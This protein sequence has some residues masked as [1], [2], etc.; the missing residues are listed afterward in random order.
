MSM[1]VALLSFAFLVAAVCAAIMGYAIQRGATC[2]VAAVDEVVTK[3]TA[4]RFLGLTEAAV[5][6]AGGVLLWR[7]LGGHETLPIGYPATLATVAGGLL[8]GLGA[9]VTRA[10]VFG[11]IAKF[12]S[13]EWAY[14]LTPIGFYLGCLTIW[15]LIGSFPAMHVASPLFDA[16][17]LLLPFAA[18][19]SWRLVEA[20]R[21]GR[22]RMLAAHIWTPHR[23]TAVIGIVFAI[24]LIAIGPWA[25]TYALLSLAQ[26]KTDGVIVKAVLMVMLFAGALVGGWTAGRLELRAPTL[27]SAIRCLGGGV[28]MGWGSLLIPGGNDELLLVGIPLLQAYAWV[29]VASMAVAIALG[30]AVERRFVTR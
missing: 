27:E 12:G 30:L 5:W 6:V 14:V 15:P 23:A 19:V 22:A 21:A 29:A 28:L 10:C 11:A 7:V 13:G 20:I 25:Y 9:F 18:F 1:S 4:W 8:L 26:G 16:G 24:S 2:M 3:R 17:W